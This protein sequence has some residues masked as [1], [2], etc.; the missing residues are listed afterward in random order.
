MKVKTKG[1]LTVLFA[2]T[3]AITL[4]FISLSFSVDLSNMLQIFIADIVATFIIYFFGVIY[5]NSSFYDPYWSV[6]PPIIAFYWLAIND[7]VINTPTILLMTAVLFWSL[8]LTYN[9]MKTWDG[10]HHEDWRY[11]DM[12]KNL[13]DNFEIVGN[14]GGIHFFPTFIV[15]FCCM[16]MGQNF[17]NEYNW[18]IFVGFGLCI[19]GVL[20]EIISDRQLHNFRKIYPSGT[21]I[22]ET[23][24]WKYSRHPNYYGEIIFW[25]GIFLFGYSFSGIN[26]L[27]LAPISM[28]AMFWFA[29]I[30][31]IE[32]KILRTRPQ[33]KNYQKR[34][35]I[36]FPEITILKRFING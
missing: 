28:T 32:N 16:P 15:F 23:G 14:L 22:I 24:L 20:Y 7:Y 18:T 30:P 11:I 31:W 33:Y 4:G 25:W 10:L 19:I 2:Y 36:L 5:K 27:I 1:L 8:R 26:Y 12:R 9:W 3:C 35:H 13:G 29:S 34:V 21:G 6:I 17:M